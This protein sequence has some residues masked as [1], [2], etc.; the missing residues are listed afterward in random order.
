MTQNLINYILVYLLGTMTVPTIIGLISIKRWI[1]RRNEKE[2][3]EE[4]ETEE[5]TVIKKTA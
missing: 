1:G 5:T 3:L 2:E 4:M